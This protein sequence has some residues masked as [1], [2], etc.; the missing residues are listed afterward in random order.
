MP[1]RSVSGATVG[2]YAPFV[3][4]LRSSAVLSS[5][6]PSSDSVTGAPSAA[7][8]FAMSVSSRVR[9]STLSSALI[10]LS[11][12]CA[13]LSPSEPS[14]LTDMKVSIAKKSVEYGSLLP[15]QPESV[16]SRRDA[17]RIRFIAIS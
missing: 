11:H 16:S 9:D 14:T 15:P 8:S 17:A 13:R 10:S 4:A 3:A 6:A 5:F 12:C 7:F 1:Q 2:S